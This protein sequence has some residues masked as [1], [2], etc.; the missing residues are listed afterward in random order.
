MSCL[1]IP[2]LE[3][4]RLFILTILLLK[5]S[6]LYP[7]IVQLSDDPPKD[8][9]GQ[10]QPVPAFNMFVA[11]TSCK[12]FSM[13]MSNKRRDIEDLGCSGE[14][15]L[16]A[17]EVLFKE[18]PR[19]AIFENVT[20]APW[21]KMSEYITGRIDIS[22]KIDKAISSTGKKGGGELE[23]VRDGDAILIE[24]VPA[25]YGVRC[26]AKV[27]GFCKV[28]STKV[29]PIYWPCD[30]T[31]RKCHLTEII[32]YNEINPKTDLLIVGNEVTYCTHL[33][34]VDTK[35]YGLPQTRQRAY[36]FVWQ[37]D[38]GIFDDD[39]GQYWEAV[40]RHLRSP[41]CHSLER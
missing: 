7:D 21:A 11:G 38:D 17:C 3:P 4:N 9:Y 23:F 14:T 25:Q 15:F 6:I 19:Y 20:K 29:H 35:E 18:K 27:E 8:V 39:L 24:R 37:P 41:V 13:L 33:I 5:D 28:G 2:L 16:A 1:F 32:K 22:G 26:G 36:L 30:V 40:V 12:N 31:N 34:K 10:H